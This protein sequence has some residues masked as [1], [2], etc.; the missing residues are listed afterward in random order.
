MK[1]S[2]MPNLYRT[3]CLHHH[4]H[5]HHH[6]HHHH[7]HHHHRHPDYLILEMPLTGKICER[8]LPP[9]DWEQGTITARRLVLSAKE[10]SG[11]LLNMDCA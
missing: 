8:A 4:H 1:A 5:H 2:Q 3:L 6:C 10:Y 7:H 11:L 9:A